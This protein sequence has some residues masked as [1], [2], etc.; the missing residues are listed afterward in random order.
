MNLVL[1]SADLISPLLGPFAFF[2]LNLTH[3]HTHKY[4]DMHT[5]IMATGTDYFE[6]CAEEPDS[7]AKELLI[8][9]CHEHKRRM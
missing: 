5:L 4:K 8:D 6:H 2:L 1:P 3:M 7:V 9:A